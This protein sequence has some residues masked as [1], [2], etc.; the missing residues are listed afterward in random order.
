MENSDQDAPI[1]KVRLCPGKNHRSDLVTKVLVFAVHYA[2]A[3]AG[4]DMKQA[5]KEMMARQKA[6]AASK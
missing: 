6:A 5:E 2:G 1:E 4:I 3:A